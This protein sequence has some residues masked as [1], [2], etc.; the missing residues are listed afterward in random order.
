MNE[1]KLVAT[2]VSRPSA[3]AGEIAAVAGVAHW[4]EVRGDLVGDLDPAALRA[5]F[6]GR[7]LYTLRSAAEGGSFN[8]PPEQ[9]LE[10]LLGAAEAGYDLVDLEADRDLDPQILAAVAPE[11]RVLSWHGAPLLEPELR[12]RFLSMAE[13]PAAL[14]KLIPEARQPGQALEPLLLLD[15]LGRRDVVA[16]AVGEQGSWTRLV[17]PHLG[18]PVVYGSLTETPGAPGQWSIARLVRDFGL[19]RLPRVEVLYG[20]VGQPVG[21]SLSPRLHNAAYRELDLPALYLPFEPESLGDF[22]L[23]VVES[24]ILPTA[25]LPLRGLSVTAP[26]KGVALALSGA[27]SPLAESV[28]AAN[29]LVWRDEVWEAET[30]DPDGVVEPLRARGIELTGAAVAVLGCG[31]AGR[32]AA[33]GL[34]HAGAHVTLVNRG[35]ERGRQ[36][37]H[38]LHLPFEPLDSWGPGGSAVVVHA[39]SLGRHDDDP[40][41]FDPDLLDG[42]AVVVDLVY[43][44]EPTPLV[45]AC[46]ARGLVAIDGREALLYQ[47][48]TQFRLMT[49]HELPLETA[50]SALGLGEVAEIRTP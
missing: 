37:A 49:G 31:G 23:E 1:A 18:A 30:T 12:R 2:L 34:A 39:T 50:R 4:L 17:A 27:S 28:G 22:W 38:D 5:H 45:A 44:E 46:R 36:T 42:D 25:G 40:L 19:P 43:R 32:A 41:P 24:E 29:T 13:T 20:I 26:F 21:H 47:A 10:R 7:L 8:G 11:R 15:R 35:V 33:A 48:V 9:R 16:F 3:G 6:P 14:Y